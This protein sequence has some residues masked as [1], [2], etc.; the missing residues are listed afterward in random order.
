MPEVEKKKLTAEEKASKMARKTAKAAKAAAAAAEGGK[1]KK[2]KKE[3]RKRE[4]V[5]DFFAPIAADEPQAKKSSS[6]NKWYE[7][8]ESKD[9]AVTP[10][11]AEAGPLADDEFIAA[12]GIE[13]IGADEALPPLATSWKR[14]NELFPAHLMK[15]LAA[16]GFASPSPIQVCLRGSPGG[17]LGEGGAP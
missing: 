6:S 2:V 13:I 5:L 3:K 8:E 1:D 12:H 15:P 16:A 7:T 17:V 10:A 11:A 14:A 4:E 9:D